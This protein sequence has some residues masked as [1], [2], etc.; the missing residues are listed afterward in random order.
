ML[1]AFSCIAVFLLSFSEPLSL[2]LA[3]HSYCSLKG[4]WQKCEWG[5]GAEKNPEKVMSF[6]GDDKIL[7]EIKMT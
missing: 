7:K 1:L 5:Q 2:L 3:C 4:C 6:E